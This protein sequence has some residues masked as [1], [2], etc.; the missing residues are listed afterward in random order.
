M[1]SIIQVYENGIKVRYVSDNLQE[2]KKRCNVLNN[3]DNIEHKFYIYDNV[4]N[5][6]VKFEKGKDRCCCCK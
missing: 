4:E 6:F 3:L 2:A 5:K 1:Y